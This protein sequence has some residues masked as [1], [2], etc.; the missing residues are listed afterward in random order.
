MNRHPPRHNAKDLPSKVG[1]L[2]FRQEGEWWA[3]YCAEPGNMVGAVKLGTILLRAIQHPQ[4]KADFIALMRELV[5]DVIEHSIGIRPIWPTGPEIAPMHER[6]LH[7]QLV[8]QEG[9]PDHD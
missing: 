8:K 1:R 7:S 6:L 5:G 3:A 2:A 4:R 9:E